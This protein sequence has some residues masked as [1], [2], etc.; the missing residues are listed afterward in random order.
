MLLKTKNIDRKY[1]FFSSRRSTVECTTV[2]PIHAYT[3]MRK[4]KYEWRKDL[5]L[6]AAFRDPCWRRTW[7]RRRRSTVMTKPTWCSQCLE[8][9]SAVIA[10]RRRWITRPSCGTSPTTV[11]HSRASVVVDEGGG[12][13][14]VFKNWIVLDSLTKVD[15]L[16]SE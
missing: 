9:P 6:H 14:G 1:F 4:A 10:E 16:R 3:A 11:L 12:N 15:F 13:C 2:P 5:V 7:F 8:I